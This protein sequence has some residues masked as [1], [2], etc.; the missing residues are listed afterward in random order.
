[1]TKRGEKMLRLMDRA[2][3]KWH[4]PVIGKEKAA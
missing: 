4:I 1:M 3:S 2:V